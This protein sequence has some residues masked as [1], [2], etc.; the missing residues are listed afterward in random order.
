MQCFR[1]HFILLPCL[2]QCQTTTWMYVSYCFC[3]KIHLSG[4]PMKTTFLRPPSLLT[5]ADFPQKLSFSLLP[6]FHPLNICHFCCISASA[7]GNMLTWNR[8]ITQC[9]MDVCYRQRMRL[10]FNVS[11]FSYAGSFTLYT[12]QS[13]GQSAGKKIE[14]S[15]ASRLASLLCQVRE[16]LSNISFISLF[17]SSM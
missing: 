4:G 13:L 16:T 14:T 15:V 9:V 10:I 7:E 3:M 8:L 1:T 11:V 12:C 5:A 6:E 2:T 17:C